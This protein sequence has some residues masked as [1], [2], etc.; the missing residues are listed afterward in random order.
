MGTERDE[1]V[2]RVF[3]ALRELCERR[4]VV[5]SEV[6]LRWGIPDERSEQVMSICL[7]DID[8]CRPWFVGIVGGRYGWVPG[9]FSEDLLAREPWLAEFADRSA[10]ELEILHGA[11][12]DP[13]QADHARIYLREGSTAGTRSSS[14]SG[15]A[16]ARLDDLKQRLRRS[17]LPVREGFRDAK[18]LGDWVLEDLRAVLDDLVPESRSTSAAERETASQEAFARALLAGYVDRP[19]AFAQIGAAPAG[20]PVV[21]EGEAGAGKSVLLARLVTRSLDAGEGPAPEVRFHFAGSPTESGDWAAMLRRWMDPGDGRDH[22]EAG[23]IRSAS[24]VRE[25]FPSWLAA[26]AKGAGAAGILVV[27]DG[28]ER[29]T[30]RPGAMDAGWLPD[31]LPAGARVVLSARPGPLVDALRARGASVVK[32][33]PLDATTRREVIRRHL[34][35]FGKQ[36]PAE[37][38]ERLSRAPIA[39]NPLF[40][41][42]VI[43]EAR[44]AG[45]REALARRLDECL[46]VP[47]PDALYDLVLARCEREFDTPSA[48]LVGRAL[49]AVWASRRGLEERELLGIL[50]REGQP[51]PQAEFAPL[52]QALRL[53]L[54]RSAGRFTFAHDLFR[55]AVGRRYLPQ[56]RDRASM[57]R[58][59]AGWFNREARGRRQFEE[60][61]WGYAE[62]GDWWNVSVVLCHTANLPTAL[63]ADPLG[64]LELWARLEAATPIRMAEA[65][66]DP[67][68][69]SVPEEDF[70]WAAGRVLEAA[71]HHSVSVTIWERLARRLADSGEA[72]LR[73]S[74]LNNAGIAS[75]HLHRLEEAGARLAEVEASA[76]DRGDREALRRALGNRGMVLLAS[77]QP[78]AALLLH[79]EEERLSRE[80]RDEAG[81]VAA[82]G[83]QGSC[84]HR[85]GRLEEAVEKFRRQ[86]ALA[87]DL[88]DDRQRICALGNEALVAAEAGEFGRAIALHEREETLC[89]RLGTRQALAICLMNLAECHRSNRDYEASFRRLHQARDVGDELGDLRM[90]A[91]ALLLEA[92]LLQG[93]ER[94]DEAERVLA[95]L[96][97]RLRDPNARD[98]AM[99]LV[100]VRADAALR[101]SRFVDALALHREQGRLAREIRNPEGEQQALAGEAGARLGAGE[102][103]AALEALR[104]E[105]EVCRT[106]AFRDALSW[107]LMRRAVILCRSLRRPAEAVTVAADALQVSRSTGR[108]TFEA[109]IETVLGESRRDAEEANAKAARAAGRSRADLARDDEPYLRAKPI[110]RARMF[111]LSLAARDLERVEQAL[112]TTE[113]LSVAG[114]LAGETVSVTRDD[115]AWCRPLSPLVEAAD[116]AAR[117]RR[118]EEAVRLYEDVLARAPGADVLLSSVGACALG[119]GD[120]VRAVRWY[121][122]AAEITPRSDRI[123][124][125]LREARALAGV[126]E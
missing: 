50:G 73:A 75:F 84:L 55:E 113:R 66:A 86:Q 88:G 57:H 77:D 59:V 83:G 1:L 35:Q 34:S 79:E 92:R 7:A 89:R 17:S 20:R 87:H 60:V 109:Q 100:G 64:V 56:E 105:E 72:A 25:A 39:G 81:V 28:L 49:S 101:R 27:V 9:R 126:R 114:G 3:P 19:D 80:A 65:Y 78:S 115:V 38:E 31:T 91:S 95:R 68:L 103:E 112:R 18:T 102:P 94:F 61:T 93:L 42:T 104:R 63:E 111:L 10:T 76:R 4:G 118:F 52:R 120:P 41:R 108:R 96:E 23:A 67:P 45:G 44:V 24:E 48:A 6:D 47:G 29:M 13:A 119:L 53:H 21:V 46:A 32:V 117:E 62:A 90:E 26:T 2:R 16:L 70:A 8:E 98:L 74:A 54:V 107:C 121:E 22:R 15:E 116:E 30:E 123:R 40:L 69:S 85:L 124:E 37:Q 106:H 12:N 71:G 122:R 125:R 99:R 51:L 58:I 5:L 82:I 11:L 14:E 36:L 97:P 110:S 33:A 43:E